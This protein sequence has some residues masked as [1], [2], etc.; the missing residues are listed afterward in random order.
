MSAFSFFPTFEIEKQLLA[1]GCSVIAGVDE[2]GRGALA[3]PLCV[4]AVIFKASHITSTEG[5]I[6]GIHDSKKLSHQQRVAGLDI[7]RGLSLHATS[8]LVS[9]RTIDRLNINGATEY[10]LN[11]LMEN[12][13][14]R[15]DIILLD[16]NFSFQSIIPIRS[17]PKGDT[18]SISIAAASIVAKVRRD[19]IME[20]FDKIFP[21]YSFNT[22][23][24]YGTN[25]HIE[26]LNDRGPSSI[27]RLSYEPV[28]SMIESNG[29]PG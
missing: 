8:I 16:G 5:P 18:R 24:G 12:I 4:G 28:R 19:L 9:H 17:I 11:L 22:N 21:G 14:I 25:L 26:A 29:I 27:H 10:A 3:G 20:R 1:E 13:S 2:V 7:I 6:K 23:K 15:P